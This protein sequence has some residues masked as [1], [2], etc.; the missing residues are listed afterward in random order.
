MVLIMGILASVAAQKFTGAVEQ[1][2][3]DATR[4]E[5]DRIATAV[6][7]DPNL[8]SGGVRSDFGYV[9]DVGALPG[10]LD[11]LVTNPGGYTTWQGPYLGNDFQ[12]NPNDY[13]QDAWGVNYSFTGI[14]VSSSGSGSSVTKQIAPSTSSLLQNSVVGTVT[15]GLDNVPGDS[16]TSVT[17]ALV[18]PNGTG[19]TT[20]VT[21]NPSPGGSFSFSGNVPVGNHLLRAIYQ[22]DTVVKYVSV[23][24]SASAVVNVRLPGDLWSPSGGGPGGGG[25]GGLTYVAGSAATSGGNHHMT[26]QVVNNSG[27]GINI[28]SIVA[29]YA[30]AIY[31]QQILIGGNQ[32]FN[33][34]NPRGASGETKVFTTVTVNNGQTL[35]FEY[36]T[37]KQC[38][39][40][41]CGNANVQGT[42]FTIS[43]SDGS[44]VNFSVP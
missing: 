16:S 23:L 27:A 29:T 40:G 8:T 30:P 20:T 28:T 12:Q 36:R 11:A 7:G 41:N 15:D 4:E 21:T 38:S 43:F 19:G 17:V 37:F 5:M 14:A 32:V 25:P 18:R 31:F 44:S 33:D 3:F 26:F 42:S 34:L 39:S 2:R 1:S 6:V 10:S 24:P 13:K 9:G 35:A 22:T